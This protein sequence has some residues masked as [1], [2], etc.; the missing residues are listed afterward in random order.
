VPS[1]FFFNDTFIMIKRRVFCGLALPLVA[2]TTTAL[3][4][5][6]QFV[7]GKHYL[8]VSPR[9]PTKDAKQVEVLEF[10]AY[11]CSHC[12]AFEPALEAWLKKL[13]RD[14]LFRRIPVAFR[15]DLVIHQQLYFAL[16]ALG[17]V[18]QLHGKV[19]HAIHGERQRLAAAP[20]IAA[21]A[22]KNGADGKRI[23]ETMNSFGVAG[24]V[25]QATALAAGYKIEGTPSL[26]VDGRW[27]TSGSLA[28][29][30]PRSLAVADHLIALAKKAG[31]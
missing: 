5:Q 27:L 21:F 29:S 4:A 25:R 9:Q 17:M 18:E 1:F 14:V 7:E 12:N 23:V 26:G 22:A 3:H 24:K 28:G 2:G 30:N 6:E 20:E 11:S 15:E 31:K 16:E 8:E 10:F 19:F 13:P